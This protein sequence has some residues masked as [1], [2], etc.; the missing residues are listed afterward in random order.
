M[1]ELE[2]IVD[3]GQWDT[4]NSNREDEVAASCSRQTREGKGNATR[5]R[6][7]ITRCPSQIRRASVVWY[8]MANPNPTNVPG[9]WHENARDTTDGSICPNPH[10]REIV[11][12]AIVATE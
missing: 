6:K 7:I 2:G 10:A 12:K 8:N 11:S 5:K 4:G 1:R 9:L 3:T